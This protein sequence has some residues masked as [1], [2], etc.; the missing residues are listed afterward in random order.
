VRR[1]MKPSR[2]FIDA[3]TRRNTG[4]RGRLVQAAYFRQALIKIGVALW[5]LAGGKGS[6]E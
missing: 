4:D 2:A 5:A 1:Q 6:P 3:R